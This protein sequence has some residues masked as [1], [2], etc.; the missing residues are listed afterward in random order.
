MDWRGWS[1][2]WVIMLLALGGSILSAVHFFPEIDHVIL[3][4]AIL[5]GDISIVLAFALAAALKDKHSRYPERDREAKKDDS[6]TSIIVDALLNESRAY[7]NQY[8]RHENSKKFREWLTIGAVITTAS[9]VILQWFEMTKV[10]TPIKESA[11]TAKSTLTDVQRAFLFVSDLDTKPTI[12][13]E[14]KPTL[15]LFPKWTNSGSTQTKS[16]N[17]F[18]FCD[19]DA[20]KFDFR[21]RE[22]DDISATIIGPKQT[23]AHG[24][25][26][27]IPNKIELKSGLVM[28]FAV[29]AKA[30]YFD[31]F[32]KGYKHVSEFCVT[33]PVT[34]VYKPED[35]TVTM[36][37]GGT[38]TYCPK[39]NCADEECP[40]EDRQ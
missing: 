16:L 15:R 29:G 12:N 32:N 39:H 18:S 5:L 37:A 28:T 34:Q 25:C 14:G 31:I 38:F 6:Q 24:H 17:I 22:G 13:D 4:I 3:I 27:A 30:T 1:S 21:I 20:T 7:R 36:S 26:D 23:K 11:D 8:D 40:E 19:T 9:F 33:V 2:F 35:G 10:Y